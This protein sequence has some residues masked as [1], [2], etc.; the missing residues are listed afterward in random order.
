MTTYTTHKTEMFV[1]RN[2]EE[3]VVLIQG[4]VSPVIPARLSGRP[5]DCY[6]AEGGEVL[7]LTA[8]VNGL[9]FELTRKEEREAEGYLADLEAGY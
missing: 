5:E 3:I 9:P 4:D 8:T 7:N 6:P 2:G 1:T